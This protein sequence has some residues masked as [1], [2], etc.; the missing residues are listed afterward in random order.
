MF[1]LHV[2]NLAIFRVCEQ[3]Y[4]WGFWFLV[5]KQLIYNIFCFQVSADG[6]LKISFL[7]YSNEAGTCANDR[8]CD[9]PVCRNHCDFKFTF[10]LQPR[11]EQLRSRYLKNLLNHFRAEN[12]FCWFTARQM[13]IVNG[14]VTERTWWPEIAMRSCLAATWEA[15]RI[16]SLYLSLAQS[17]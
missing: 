7:S 9:W 14:V 6:S 5:D 12:S 3:D 10:C 13:E 4:Y 1:K 8:C 16:L 11:W 15:W 2:S 17:M